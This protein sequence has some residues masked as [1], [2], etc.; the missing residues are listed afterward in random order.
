MD[1][2]GHQHIGV[3]VSLMFDGRSA[4]DREKELVVGVRAKN[5]HSVHTALNDVVWRAWDL[6]SSAAR[7]VRWDCT[8]RGR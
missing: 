6:Q 3:N 2:V 5:V 4:E 1:V 7:H 8:N